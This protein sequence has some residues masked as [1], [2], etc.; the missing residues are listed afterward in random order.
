MSSL[1][2][3]QVSKTVQRRDV[4]LSFGPIL[5]DSCSEMRRQRTAG[6]DV[7][8]LHA[9]IEGFRERKPFAPGRAFTLK[10]GHGAGFSLD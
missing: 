7:H 8:V 5:S 9:Q 6:S 2:I 4:M 3:R 1:C 10:D